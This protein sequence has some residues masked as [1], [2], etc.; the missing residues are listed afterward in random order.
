[1]YTWLKVPRKS[2][3]ALLARCA[4]ASDRQEKFKLSE[5]YLRIEIYDKRQAIYEDNNFMFSEIFYQSD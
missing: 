5:E 4:N 3:N 2:G 1:M